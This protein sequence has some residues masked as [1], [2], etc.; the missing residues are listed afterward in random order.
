[1]PKFLQRRLVILFMAL[2][3]VAAIWYNFFRLAPYSLTEQQRQQAFEVSGAAD[4]SLKMQP[5]STTAWQ[6]TYTSFDGA[7]VNGQ[8]HYP[9]PPSEIHHKIPVLIGVHAMGRSQIRWWQDSFNGSPTLT[10]VHKLS[11]MALD[12]GYAVVAIDAREH[13]QRKNPERSLKRIMWGLHLWGERHHYEAMIH[14]TVVDHR[15]LLDWL[16]TQPQFDNQQLHVAGYSMGAQVS[17]LLAAVDKRISKVLAVVPPHVDDK[18]ALVSVLQWV[19]G[20]KDNSVTLLSAD[21][22]EHASQEDNQRLF[23]LIPSQSK[24]HIR[25]NAGHIL[26][27]DYPTK[28]QHW[29]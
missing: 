17:L 24:Q 3:G 26:P 16:S 22:D 11:R 8:L 10:Q 1:M 7:T 21:N 18:T 13:G 2:V 9:A 28:L 19:A 14:D 20:L 25:F 4:L 6:F 15:I 29:F 27:E 23:N 12:A 5:L